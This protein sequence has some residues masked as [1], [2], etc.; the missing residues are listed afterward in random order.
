MKNPKFHEVL[1]RLADIHDKKNSDY[2][3]DTD[4]YANFRKCEGWGLPAH[5]GILVRIGDKMSRIE[6]FIQ[7]ESF[8]V[9]DESFQDTCD[10]L[11]NY[12]ILLGLV[13]KEYKNKNGKK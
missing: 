10:D 3:N 7:K 8:Q 13:Y 11:A 1:K 6:N 5:K 4:P 9:K 2:A 12:A